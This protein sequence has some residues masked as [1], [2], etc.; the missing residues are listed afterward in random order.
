MLLK[1]HMITM[2]KFQSLSS[3]SILALGWWSPNYQAMWP[4]ASW[5]SHL[6]LGSK[7]HMGRATYPIKNGNGMHIFFFLF[8][9]FILCCKLYDRLWQKKLNVNKSYFCRTNLFLPIKT[10]QMISTK[11]IK[12]KVTFFP[13]L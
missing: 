8:S 6:V 5:F 13:S 4:Y 12:K 9:I 11:L 3:P 2:V 10:Q 1:Y 7:R